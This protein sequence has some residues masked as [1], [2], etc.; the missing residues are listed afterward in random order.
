MEFLYNKL[1]KC[2]VLIQRI[3]RMLFAVPER[4]A[5]IGLALLGSGL[6]VFNTF[7]SLTRRVIHGDLVAQQLMVQQWTTGVEH[8]YATAEATNYIL[9]FPLYWV[10]EQLVNSPLATVVAT[11][12]IL[13]I[14][15]W[16]LTWFSLYKILVLVGWST[17]LTRAALAIMMTYVAV[18]SD[19]VYWILFPN[20]RNL[21]V[22]LMVFVLYGVLWAAKSAG[23]LKWYSYVLLSMAFG[24]IFINDL[25]AMALVAAPLGLFFLIKLL[26]AISRKAAYEEAIGYVAP[27]VIIGLGAVIYKVLNRYVLSRIF[28]TPDKAD[29][30]SIPDVSSALDTVAGLVFSAL[31]QLGL[32]VFGRPLVA[33]DTIPYLINWLIVGVAVYA[34]LKVR[35]NVQFRNDTNLQAVACVVALLPVIIFLTGFSSTESVDIG[36]ARYMIILPFL[37]MLIF[38][39]ALRYLN[40]R[41]AKNLLIG[42]MLL[43]MSTTVVFC[44]AYGRETAA[45]VRS[46]VWRSGNTRLYELIDVVKR[47]SVD[48]GYSSIQTAQSVTYFT[49]QRTLMLP[50]ACD[51]SLNTRP[52]QYASD[53]LIE[54]STLFKSSR[55]TAIEVDTKPSDYN[56]C[57]LDVVKRQVGTDGLVAEE[58]INGGNQTVLIYDRD[59][60]YNLRPKNRDEYLR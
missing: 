37:C 60:M 39:G 12:I 13:N 56:S 58:K 7:F 48:K 30:S 17:K 21:E 6:L 53:W 49:D 52:V 24:A 14:V 10:M 40:R 9:K 8:I 15:G 43:V 42:L 28:V 33:L 16:G 2:V 36:S 38:V 46:E 26:V 45:G 57:S 19:S 27:L 59:I 34:I 35:K 22:A 51:E 29:G 23:R 5:Y 54:A 11:A 44:G 18:I 50:V 3:A 47:Y 31:H 20:S 4:R 1:I 55:R 32:N 25:M 41:F